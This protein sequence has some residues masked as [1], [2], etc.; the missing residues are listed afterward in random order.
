MSSLHVLLEDCDGERTEVMAIY[1]AACD[2][3][4]NVA[5]LR[6]AAQ[7]NGVAG[8]H[9][10]RLVT[11]TLDSGE[12]L[13]HTGVAPWGIVPRAGRGEYAERYFWPETHVPKGHLCQRCVDDLEEW[14]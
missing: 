12:K 11:V 14:A 8:T 9:R 3:E 7:T 13:P 1:T 6:D 4:H 2:A 5:S 10:Y